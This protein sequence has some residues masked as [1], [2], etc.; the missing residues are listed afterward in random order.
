MQEPVETTLS[1][2]TFLVSA[3]PRIEIKPAN[4][5]VY[6][7]CLSDI[8]ADVLKAAALAH[9]AKSPFFPAI[10]ELRD[11][12]AG[13]M[14]RALNIPNTYDAWDEV[15]RAI[16]TH[17]HYR[18]PEF[19][20]ALIQKSVDACG[21][22]RALC[23]SENQIADRARFFQV[24]ETY[25]GREKEDNRQLPEVSSMIAALSERLGAGTGRALSSGFQVL[26]HPA[27]GE[28][29]EVR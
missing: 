6:V 25:Q 24:Y 18:R 22:W 12:A 10:A 29:L 3:Y 2:L 20:H 11:A 26:T 19:S 9:V 4:I 23:M 8:P 5:K 17:G 1:V 7:T 16:T 13:L 15:C 27:T 14:E 21:G 28:V